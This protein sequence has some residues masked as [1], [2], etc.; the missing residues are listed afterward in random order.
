MS[1]ALENLAAHDARIAEAQQ[2]ARA[3][4][5]DLAELSARVAELRKKKI[6]A[7]ADQNESLAAKLRRQIDEGQAKISDLEERQQGAELASRRASSERT[8]WIADHYRELVSALEPDAQQA[9]QTI[10]RLADELLAAVKEW[11]GVSGKVSALA[12][13]AG[14]TNQRVPNL[15]WDEI[16]QALRHRP[17]PTPLP[18]PGQRF[19]AASIAPE[20]H[21]DPAVREPARAAIK[22]K[23]RKA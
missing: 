22:E 2:R 6:S 8:K 17:K 3:L 13:A 9:A 14:Q 18:L 20:H 19:D 12:H 11:G 21:P 7:H 16:A 15:G 10:D 5:R 23:A 4:G 1:S